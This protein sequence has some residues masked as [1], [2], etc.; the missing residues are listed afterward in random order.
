MVQCAS[1]M[2][3]HVMRVVIQEKTQLYMECALKDD[4]IPLLP[5]ET[6]DYFHFHFDS[7]LISCTHVTIARHHQSFLVLVM[8]I[9]YYRQRVSIV[10]QHS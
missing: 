1:S 2:T 8:L 7:F 10:L 4:F 6:Y 5:I 9:S 3:T